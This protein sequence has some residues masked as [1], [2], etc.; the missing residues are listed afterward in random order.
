MLPNPARRRVPLAG[1]LGVVLAALTLALLPAHAAHAAERTVSGGRL[2]WGV[3]SSFLT[4]IT[5]PIAQGS[6][7]L[8]GGAGTVG[9]SQFRFHSATGG[10]DPETGAVTAAYSGGVRFQGHF[11]DQGVPELDLTISNPS[12]RVDGASGTLYADIRSKARGS[13]QV[14][15]ASGVALAS[16]NLS[17]VD[18]R[19]GSRIS[20]TGAPATLTTDG[21]TAFA[22]Y[23]AAGDPLDPV[24]FTADT[25]D[26]APDPGDDPSPDPAPSGEARDEDGAE[27]GADEADEAP[28]SA[29]ITDAALDWGVRRTFREFVTGDI[30]EGGWELADG[31][32]DGGALFRFP[33]G[34]GELDAETG[35]L[36]ANFAGSLHFTGNDLDL[37]VEAVRVEVADGEGT[38]TADVTTADGTAE[39]ARLV[40]FEVPELDVTD[41]L[42]HLSEAPAELTAEGAEA[43]GRLY[44]EGTVMDPLTLAVAVSDDAELPPLPDLGSEPVEEAEAEPTAEAEPVEAESA[45]DSSSSTPV[46]LLAAAAIALLAL[47][48]AGYL[49]RRRTSGARPATTPSEDTDKETTER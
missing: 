38:M 19:G 30:A 47:A 2:D 42:F 3:R 16:L 4:Y 20:V 27:D 45:A 33:D 36:A 31:A 48:G 26:P 22:G 12:V 39:A 24:T 29:E 40:T 10:Y 15:E 28:D 17:G 25:L 9:N 13:G 49:V 46:P 23:Y 14:N 6:W 32:Q 41:G 18:L 5:G 35:S 1:L 44:T 21:A 7:G 8:S 34:T 37:L 43:F 11:D